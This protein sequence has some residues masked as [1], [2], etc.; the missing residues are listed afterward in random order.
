MK[1]R[2]LDQVNRHAG[3]LIEM[4]NL[5]LGTDKVKLCRKLRKLEKIASLINE[6]YCN[7][8]IT[9]LEFEVEK[10]EI[11]EK[12]KRIFNNYSFIDA[13][14]YNSDTR[15]YALKLHGEYVVNWNIHKDWGGYGILAPEFN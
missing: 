7:G 11:I 14:Y 8:D 15:G 13:F 4:F 3:I 10:S 6:K 9:G 5:P 1:Q 12:V 2:I